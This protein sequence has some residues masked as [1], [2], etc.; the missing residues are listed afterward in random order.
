MHIR[1][2]AT[3]PGEAPLAVREAWVGMR[4]PLADPKGDARSV[5][6]VGVLSG[7]KSFFARLMALLLG[8]TNQVHGYR[9]PGPA[10]LAALALKDA[11][12]AQWWR[13]HAPQFL[14][15]R[16]Q[17]VFHAEVCEIVDE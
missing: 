10:A 8:R 12:A 9:V 5:R 14:Q 2:I 13:D 3:P 11:S 4:L 6:S 16:S 17:F 7:P 15:P 1:I